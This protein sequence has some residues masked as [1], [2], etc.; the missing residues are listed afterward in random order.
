[1]RLE[2]TRQIQTDLIFSQF[3]TCL[4]VLLSFNVYASGILKT[5]NISGWLWKQGCDTSKYATEIC[6]GYYTNFPIKDLI[7]NFHNKYHSLLNIELLQLKCSCVSDLSLVVIF[8]LN[9]STDCFVKC[10]FSYD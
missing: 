10:Y 7:Q 9:L 4:A 1:M 8:Y 5:S 6:F 2:F 3:V